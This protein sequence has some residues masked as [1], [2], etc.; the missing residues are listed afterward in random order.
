MMLPRSDAFLHDTTIAIGEE[1]GSLL[2][3]E[4]ARMHRR[5]R[6]RLD[7]RPAL[8]PLF[9]QWM[10]ERAM[11]FLREYIFVLAGFYVLM[12]LLT[13]PK[14]LWF[15][16]PQL[17]GSDFSVYLAL[18]L[19]LGANMLAFFLLVRQPRHDGWFW[20]YSP[21]VDVILLATSAL[22]VVFF[23]DPANIQLCLGILVVC[24]I[25]VF[26]TGM[27]LLLV[28]LLIALLALALVALVS[29]LVG[30]AAAFSAFLPIYLVILAGMTLVCHFA[31]RSHRLA[32]LQEAMLAVDKLRLARL[33]RELYELT[34]RDGLTG[35]A[36]RRRFEEALAAEC[37]RA[38]RQ[39]L[40]LSLL[41]VDVDCLGAYNR[42]RGE[43]AGDDCL[44][45]VAELL[46]QSLRRSG[47]LLARHKGGGFTLLLPDTPADGALELAIRLQVAVWR[48]GLAHEGNP[49]RQVTVSIGL[50]S[51]PPANGEEPATLLAAADKA[52]AAAKAAGRNR[53]EVARQPDYHCPAMTNPVSLR[54]R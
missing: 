7:F 3:A 11:H 26:G 21:V 29:A 9:R 8:E 49:A 27:Q 4:L 44:R 15:T 41:L 30:K 39:R 53:I 13:A 5:L 6:F 14:F 46:R 2:E 10:H 19:L 22:G 25:V 31:M 48:L 42:L 16:D 45:Q 52:L 54:A 1:S 36:N 12:V 37:E 43:A 17:H 34:E 32:F 18:V 50:A 40:P 47:D 20:L 35:V 51:L 38:L 33:T 24:F 23:S 28:C